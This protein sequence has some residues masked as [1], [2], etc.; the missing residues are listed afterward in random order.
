[1]ALDRTSTGVHRP[2]LLDDVLACLD[3]RPGDVAVDCTVGSGSHA[4]A[5]LERILPG[6]RLL[7]LDV[8][9]IELERTRTRFDAVTFRRANFRD[10][11]A[12]LSDEQI[13]GADIVF[14]DLGLSSMQH[15]TPARGFHYKFPGPL[16]MRMNPHRGET[17]AALIARLD[18]EALARVLFANADEA[19]AARIATLIKRERIETT[20]HLERVV[21]TGLA[22]ERPELT[23]AEVKLSVRR[24]FQA[25]RI[26][27]NDELRALEALLAALPACLAPRGRAAF[28]SFHSG[29]DDRIAA[30][31]RTGFENGVYSAISQQ[32][33][34][35][36]VDET[37][38]NRRALSAKLRW[39]IKA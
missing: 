29:E 2:I 25:L 30:S 15:D 33:I 9:P 11:R 5:I 22:A 12:I 39:A 20:H 16:D 4:R 19:H 37:R 14:A 38:A 28:I 13:R 10:L 36:N 17:A 8:D 31:F 7:A 3:P 23:R 32:E 21:R 6:G 18:R 34:R 35:T 24:T 1:M 27:V 26:E